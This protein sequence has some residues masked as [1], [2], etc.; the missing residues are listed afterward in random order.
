MMADV[1]Y[2]LKMFS[3]KSSQKLVVNVFATEVVK[4]TTN[5]V[6][7]NQ[8]FSF[9]LIIVAFYSLKISRFLNFFWI[10]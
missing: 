2:S 4:Q 5:A 3:W 1:T 7:F 8:I 6:V 10:D 9:R